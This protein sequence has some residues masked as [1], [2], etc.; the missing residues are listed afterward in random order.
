LYFIN[1]LSDKY[2]IFLNEQQQQAVKHVNGPAL[3][4]AGP[5]SGKTTVI[6]ARTAF[7]IMDKAV[8]PE[9]IL[10]LTFNRAAKYEMERRFKRIFGAAIGDKVRFSTL[11][12][13]CN[14][15]VRDYEYK[16][17]KRLK[18]IEGEEE[19]TESK[20]SILKG[21]Y[22]QTNESRINDDELEDLIS[23]IGLVKYKMI[24][25]FGDL[26][27]KTKNFALIFK[28]YEEYKKSNLLMDFDDMLTFAYGILIK[29]PDIL[30]YYQ[31]KYKYI[32]VDEGQDLSKVQFEI[33]KLLVKSD[34]NF[35]IVADDDQSIYAFRGAEPRYIV[36]ME[37]QF[38]D[39]KIYKLENNYRSS[40]NIVEITSNFIKTNKNRYDK[41][42]KTENEEKCNPFI[43]QVND[44]QEQLKIIIDTVKAHLNGGRREEIAVLY[45]N[46]IS[47]VVIANA[48]ELSSI[49][50][51]IKQNK[52]FFFSHWVVLDILAFLKLALN[53]GDKESF[54]RIY[55]R[56]NRFIS[57]VMAE[58]AVEKGTDSSLFDSILACSELK[59]FQQKGIIETKNEFSQLA[60]MNPFGAL[61]YIEDSFKYFEYVKNYCEN[62]GL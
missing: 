24:K 49:K 17:G 37:K 10:T 19:N 38:S 39:C 62:T 46:N 13:F 51:N 40:R 47:S 26:S 48:L 5:G 11:H 57:K 35:F 9:S 27:F 61:R 16:Q 18:R 4:L 2:S 45:R 7:L 58:G 23:E 55:Y 14:L 56:M 54:L 42:H 21:I 22:Q 25:E 28:E 53:Q 32:Q 6:T 30:S 8:D 44:E 1:L 41:D 34:R 59:P 12:S 52:L 36:D 3:V 20:R 33:L 31:N 15:V 29:C 60:K 50:F 43:L